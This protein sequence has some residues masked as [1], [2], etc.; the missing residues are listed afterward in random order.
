LPLPSLPQELSLKESSDVNT[1]S[2]YS[3]SE[4]GMLQYFRRVVFISSPNDLYVPEYSA[5]V[6]VNP[7]A[8]LNPHIG[9]TLTSMAANLLSQIEPEKLLRITLDNNVFDAGNVDKAIGRAGHIC[10]LDNMIIAEGLVYTLYS[11]FRLPK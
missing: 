5:R 9:Y 8:I 1:T 3:L 2:L 6:Q 7:K 11:I 4:N 10:Y